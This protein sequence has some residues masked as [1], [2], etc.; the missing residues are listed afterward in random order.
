MSKGILN[1]FYTIVRIFFF[2]LILSAGCTHDQVV[3]IDISKNSCKDDYNPRKVSVRLTNNTLDIDKCGGIE[4][5]VILDSTEMIGSIDKVQVDGDRIYLMDKNKTKSIFC[6]TFDGQLKWKYRKPGRGRGKFMQLGD[7]DV[8]QH[9]VYAF[10]N[11]AMKILQLDSSGRFIQEMPVANNNAFF[12]DQFFVDSNGNVV[13]YNFD[14]GDYRRF[15]YEMTMMD[16]TCK[17]ILS[18]HLLKTHDPSIKRWGSQLSPLQYYAGHTGF[19]FTKALDDTIYGYERGVFSRK[20]VIDF[21]SS[22]VPQAVREKTRYTLDDFSHSS[23]Q[24]GIERIC[25]NDSLV[26]FMFSNGNMPSYAFF[27]KNTLQ[28]RSYS[29]VMFN[30]DKYY[31]MLLPI[32]SWN[33]RVIARVEPMQLLHFFQ[34]YKKI[35]AGLT[36]EQLDAKVQHEMPVLYAM[37]QRIGT[38]SNPIL[39]FLHFSK[40]KLFP[41]DRV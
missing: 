1:R 20:Y 27:D 30:I 16:S 17:N 12:P 32:G 5:V 3:H 39:V 8:Q 19:Y 24:G 26:S 9:R 4:T 11:T 15:P 29:L 21:G 10:D 6:Y 23:Y 36:D 25:E 2:G 28:S 34:Y 35:N 38:S 41:H 33:G 40:S 7:M 18:Y 22:A 14:M 13:L 37:R 31:Q